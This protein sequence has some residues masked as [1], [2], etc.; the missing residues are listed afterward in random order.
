MKAGLNLATVVP[1]VLVVALLMLALL[2][3]FKWGQYSRHLSLRTL[4]RDVAAL[5]MS[6]PKSGDE[7]STDRNSSEPWVETVSWSPR[8]FVFHNFISHEDC[9]HIV[10]MGEAYVTRSQVVGTTGNSVQHD[11]RSSSGVFL[12]GGMAEDKSVKLVGK[13]IAE[14]TQ[15][16]EGNGEV[17]YLI[18]YEVGQ[19][20]K[21]H[22]DFFSNDA[23]GAPFIGSSGNRMATVLTYLATPDEGGETVFPEAQL[24]VKARK[25]DAVLFFNMHPDGSVDPRSLHGGLPVIKGTKW[26]MTRWIRQKHF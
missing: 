22:Y 20:Y 8:V 4:G 5:S 21:P 14:W 15:I 24:Q 7:A 12:T 6:V 16:P 23:N 3:A 18:R 26:A 13:R 9:D 17:F 11:A 2:A 1:R 10:A 19:Q 25:G